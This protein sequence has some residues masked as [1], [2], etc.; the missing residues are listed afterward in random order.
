M[1]ENFMNH[2]VFVMAGVL[3]VASAFGATPTGAAE[4][5]PVVWHDLSSWLLEGKGWSETKHR[6]DRLPAKAEG[7]V[8]SP[9]WN[10][11]ADSAGLCLRFVTDAVEIE[12]RWTLRKADRLE[13]P[14]MPA[15][16]VSGLDL[17][18]RDADQWRWIGLGRPAKTAVIHGTLVKGLPQ[19]PKREFLLYLPLY[20]GIESIALG[21]PTG[22]ALERAPDRHVARKPIVFYGTSILQGGCA[23]RPG[24]AYPAIIGRT[25]DW[26]TVNLGFSGNGKAEPEMAGLLAELDP[27]VYVLDSLPNLDAAQAGERLEP[28]VQTLRR[29]HPQTPIVLVENVNYADTGLVET[30]R[31]KVAEVNLLLRGLHDRMQAAGDKNVYYIRAFELLGGDGDDTVDGTHPTDLGFFRMAQGIAPIVRAALRGAGAGVADEAGF[32]SLF[33]GKTLSGWKRHDEFSKSRKETPAGKWWVEDGVLTG[34]PSPSRQGGFL[35]L[36]RPFVDFVLKLEVRLDYPIDTGVFLRTGPTGRSHQVM[37]DY[38]PGGDIGAIFIPFERSVHRNQEGIRAFRK[39]AWNEMEIRM[40]GE[41][42]RIRV[43]LNGYMITDFQ[44]TAETNKG[45]SARGGIALQVHPNAT[46]PT[47]W[48]EGNAVRYRNIRIKQL[49]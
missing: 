18:V 38:L 4:K 48:R 10:L 13:L 14:H 23:S 42:A 12:A 43:W 11:A 27:A 44:H 2:S 24:M 1:E 8:R 37:L 6:Y 35:W 39:D 46:S 26:P 19:G 36:D 34:T 15:T 41:P 3:F 7:L 32:E 22:A 25:L 40:E 29:T 28:F 31:K 20:N 47:L 33:D 21:L 45:A 5:R 9:V 30:R 49:Q 16:G 17:Y